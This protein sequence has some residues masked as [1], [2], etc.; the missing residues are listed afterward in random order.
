MI[1]RPP[2]STL[3]P[4]TTLFRSTFDEADIRLT[5]AFAD[6]AA[7]ALENARL[8]ALET[9]RRAHIETLA[10]VER[11]LAAELDLDRLLALIVERAS[12]LFGA[13][14]AIYLVE[15]AGQTLAPSAWSEGASFDQRITFGV[16]LVGSCALERQGRLVNDYAASPYARPEPVGGGARHAIVQ[17]LVLRDRLLGVIGLFPFWW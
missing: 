13:E 16:G 10:A 17:P 4:Y 15:P 2:R 11:E 8:F 5:E 7:L 6:Q 12:R 9:A 3:F 14:G 1:R